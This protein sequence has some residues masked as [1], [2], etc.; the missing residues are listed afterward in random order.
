MQGN[1]YEYVKDT[2][3]DSQKRLE[4]SAVDFRTVIVPR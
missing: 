3:T 2:F 4:E 1:V